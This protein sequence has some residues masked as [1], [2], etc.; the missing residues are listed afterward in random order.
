V[1]CVLLN[2]AHG[3]AA[4]MKQNYTI[5]ILDKAPS[6]TCTFQDV[7]GT[8]QEAVISAQEIYRK[9]GRTVT[10]REGGDKAGYWYHRVCNGVAIDR[11][12]VPEIPSESIIKP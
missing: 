8:Y 1:F 4:A 9:I 11:N 12:H 2:A 10:L 6:M 3:Y 5:A 7:F